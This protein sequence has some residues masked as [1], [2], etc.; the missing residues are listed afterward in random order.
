M[1]VMGGKECLRYFKSNPSY[2]QIPIVMLS[3]TCNE[4]DTGEF[5]ALG[6]IDCIKKPNGFNDLV[7]ILSK[8]VFEKYL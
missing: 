1:P 3:T 2:S 5:K 4:K 7:Q 6:A 8:F